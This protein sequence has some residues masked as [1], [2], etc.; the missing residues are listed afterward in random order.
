MSKQF[1]L[2]IH[3]VMS[4]D[5]I[6]AKK[7]NSTSWFE[8]NDHFENGIELTK[9]QT[10]D[11]L[12]TIDCYIMG[13]NTYLHALQLSEQYGWAYGD[14]PVVVVTHKELPVN[15]ENVI[16]FSGDLENL[17]NEKLKTKYNSVWIVGGAMLAEEFLRLN[18]ADEIRL[19]VLPI[20]LGEG[21]HFFNG[22]AKEMALHLK[23]IT[24]FKNGMVEL[25][26]EIKKN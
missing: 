10:Q 24:A 23:E 8:T 3:M 15:R 14:V 4:L 17:V 20:I 6:I 9:Q 13:A 7:D 21:L 25:Y 11:F 26:Y 5:G 22:I 12:K 2:T 19:S 18:L 1:K 16:L